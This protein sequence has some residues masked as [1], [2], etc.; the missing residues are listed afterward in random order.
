MIA[1]EWEIFSGSAQALGAAAVDQLAEGDL[2]PEGEGD[3]R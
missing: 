2:K 1:A 3:A